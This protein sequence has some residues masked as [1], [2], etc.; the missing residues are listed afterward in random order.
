MKFPCEGVAVRRPRSARVSV[1][2]LDGRNAPVRP[3]PEDRFLRSVEGERTGWD[4]QSGAERPGG[5][6]DDFAVGRGISSLQI[7]ASG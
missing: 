6:G 3:S 5:N 2:I 1:L 4:W 7:A